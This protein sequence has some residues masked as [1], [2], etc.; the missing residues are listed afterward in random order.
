MQAQI[1]SQDFAA[2]QS[3]SYQL[4]N[5]TLTQIE[6]P[7]NSSVSPYLEGQLIKFYTAL[8]HSHVAPTNYVEANAQYLGMDNR[9][10]TLAPPNI[11]YYSDMSIWDIHRTQFPLMSFL[12]PDVASDILNSLV[13]MYEQGL[14]PLRCIAITRRRRRHP[15]LADGECVHGLHGRRA[16]QRDDPRRLCQGPAKRQLHGACTAGHRPRSH[17]CSW[18]TRGCTRW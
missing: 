6:I 16:C 9:V 11:N 3:S 13:L 4:W 17:H 10:H 14:L 18:H 15:T 5:T 7:T 1:G 2:C 12:R 8:Y